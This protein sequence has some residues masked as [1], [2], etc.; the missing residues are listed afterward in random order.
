MSQLNGL[1]GDGT[2]PAAEGAAAAPQQLQALRATV[3]QLKRF[4]LVV[5]HT[6]NIVV[7]TD[8]AKRIE[9]VNAAYCRTTGW[10]LQDVRG[11]RPGQVL[12]G[13]DSDPATI[14][15]LSTALSRGE[16]VQ[17]VEIL[18]YKRNGDTYWVSLNIQAVRN[19]QG[20]ITHYVAIESDV[21][22]RR[23]ERLALEASQRQLAQ[24][25]QLARIAS[26]ECQVRDDRM[27]WSAEAAG[28]LGCAP[29]ALPRHYMDHVAA[30]HP[31][32][33]D[34][35]LEA[36]WALLA[37]H[38]PYELS[39][40]LSGPTLRW[41]RERGSLVPAG[42][43][44]VEQHV[45]GVIQDITDTKVAQARMEYLARHDSL[46]GL[47][48]R[49]QLRAALRS[50]MAEGAGATA[51]FAVL[52][53]DLDR[54]K[55]INDS[56][57]HHVGD[58]VLK[59]VGRRLRDALRT[60]DV[61]CRLGGDEFVVVLAGASD[62]ETA[63][64][65]GH[66]ILG[67]LSQPVSCEGRE[68]HLTASIGVSR[69]PQDGT[70]VDELMRHA[71]IAMYQAKAQGRNAVSHYHPDSNHCT[72]ERFDL[73]SRLRQAV[74]RKELCLHYQPQFEAATQ[75]L[76]GFEAL[77]RWYPPDGPPVPPAAFIPV[78]E[79][80]GL[81]SII[82]SWALE[83][84]CRQW[85]AWWQS[86][87][88]PVRMAVNL[89]ACQL[90]PDHDLIGTVARLVRRYDL[91]PDALELELTESVAMSDPDA[92]VAL[93]R[94]LRELGV[95]LAVDDFGTGYSSLAYLKLL[96]IQR[97][98]LDRSFVSHIETDANDKAI[99]SAT[100]ALAH[101]LGLEVVAEGVETAAQQAYLVAQGC[102]VMQGYLLG[103]PAAASEAAACLSRA[104]P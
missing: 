3:A 36:H 79:E 24:A 7:I 26:F 57:G 95:S 71:D 44:G 85:R 96:P 47:H 84:A 91:P 60:T 50:L 29:E 28:L 2:P 74:A 52:F 23:R 62:A 51:P 100:I 80:S 34:A 99:C 5:E 21:S 25:Q 16:S 22:E 54:F 104:G 86:H 66:K 77:L 75:R 18:N 65:L 6:D 93:M 15:R 17:D 72:A 81:I 89:S 48:N 73:E 46:T 4:Q 102:D 59:E 42:T 19:V 12:Q 30:V 20:Q 32:D 37:R 39:Y 78:A 98:K 92:S 97:L 40:R 94:Q 49:D 35:L 64:R 63:T 76:V 103:R 14:R 61:V 68:L 43:D 13:P 10:T 67:R 53:V 11:R 9:Y 45:S 33:R 69:Y 58:Q 55:V 8:A 56:L 101:S 90:R 83:Q 31:D 87:G 1:S 41:L 70:T 38:T 27:Q 82:G 88:V